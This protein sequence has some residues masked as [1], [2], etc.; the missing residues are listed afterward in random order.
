MRGMPTFVTHDSSLSLGR[1]AF[2]LF[3][4]D[5]PRE[6]WDGCWPSVM[7]TGHLFSR[8]VSA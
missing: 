4:R 7:F 5:C 1:F 2:F 6:L 3:V 8:A